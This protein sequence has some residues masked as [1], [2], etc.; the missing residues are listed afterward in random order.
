MLRRNLTD[1]SG[2][3]WWQDLSHGAPTISALARLCSNALIESQL[4]LP[5]DEAKPTLDLNTL[6]AEA[7]AL[8]HLAKQR[9]TFEIRAKKDGFDSAERFLAVAVEVEPERWRLLLEKATPRQ[10]IRFLEAFASLCQAGLILH[11]VQ[12]EFS[13]SSLGFEKATELE[14]QDAG[15]SGLSNYGV[16]LDG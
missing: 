6:S 10:T 5:A 1:P 11:H 8:L 15:V 12:A 7:R 4:T 3:T 16:E 13:F 9:G 14:D 2:Q